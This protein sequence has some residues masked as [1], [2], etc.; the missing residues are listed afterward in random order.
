MKI[1]KLIENNLI[2]FYTCDA[3][4]SKAELLALFTTSSAESSISRVIVEVSE[5]GDLPPAPVRNGG[6]GNG[7]GSTLHVR[8]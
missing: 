7:G 1:T 3:G 5:D 4:P 8:C 2:Q 6:A